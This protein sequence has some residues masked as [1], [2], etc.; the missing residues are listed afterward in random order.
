M[1]LAAR[2][3]IATTGARAYLL[4]LVALGVLQAY[5][6]G[7]R[8]VG[9]AGDWI[10]YFL[11]PLALIGLLWFWARWEGFGL[12]N[13]GWVLYEKPARTLAL[14]ALLAGAYLAV[15]FEA[16]LFVGT[17]SQSIPSPPFAILLVLAAPIIA[18]AQVGIFQGYFLRRLAGTGRFLGALAVSSGAFALANTNLPLAFVLPVDQAGAYLF[19]TAGTSFA[20]G[21]VLGVFYYKSRWSI[22]GPLSLDA[23]LLLLPYL[24]PLAARATSWEFVF[25]QQLLSVCAVLALIVL[26]LREPGYLAQHYLGEGYGPRRYRFLRRSRNRA[27]LRSGAV[28]LLIVVPVCLGSVLGLQAWSGSRTPLLAIAS[29]SMD[30]TLARGDL[31]LIEH[32]DPSQ[33]S[34]GTII[35]YSGS[36][37]PSPTVHRVIEIT[38]GPGSS[39]Y[40]TQ[41]DANPSPDPCPVS[42]SQ[43]LGK[44]VSVVPWIGYLI[45][46]PVLSM[47]IVALA[48]LLPAALRRKEAWPLHQYPGRGATAA[49]ET[50][51]W[52]G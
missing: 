5:Y 19:L 52:G 51:R 42:Y 24:L 45:L 2:T 20:L 14:V 8:F 26:I 16:A 33:I 48:V 23:V 28:A 3:R 4:P 36:C 49:S 10:A 27:A 38:N 39:R 12:R 40:I 37:L 30:P 43:I 6:Y 17:A 25:L 1:E 18:L 21:I 7:L 9:P 41:G 11:V 32:V 31:V 15:G 44:V 47:S 29:G 50:G 35:A 34:V 13:V 22:L 46:Q